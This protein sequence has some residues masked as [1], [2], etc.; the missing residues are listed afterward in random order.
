MEFQPTCPKRDLTLQNGQ[1]IAG[2]TQGELSTE[3]MARGIDTS[4][5]ITQLLD[6]LFDSRAV[7]LS[8]ILPTGVTINS[9]SVPI[10]KTQI[11][12]RGGTPR[13]LKA[14]LLI[15]LLNLR[16]EEI[17][18]P[19]PIADS[20][21]GYDGAQP[22][23][24]ST[25]G[26]LVFESSSLN[27]AGSHFPFAKSDPIVVVHPLHL[28]CLTLRDCKE[29]WLDGVGPSVGSSG[30]IKLSALSLLLTSA[31]NIGVDA[32]DLTLGCTIQLSELNR[33][34]D[35]VGPYLVGTIL[36]L[37]LSQVVETFSNA[38]QL[39]PIASILL[40]R[41][42]FRLRE[43]GPSGSVEIVGVCTL[44]KTNTWS[45][46]PYP[47]QRFNVLN[48]ITGCP[49]LWSMR[50]PATLSPVIAAI[51]NDF[52]GPSG[53]APSGI[54]HLAQDRTSFFLFVKNLFFHGA[55]P[56][57]VFAPS[58]VTYEAYI[59]YRALDASYAAGQH[60]SSCPINTSHFKWRRVLN[61]G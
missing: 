42:S 53:L 4:G 8:T 54:S 55:I 3:L 20:V 2:M 31:C 17:Y 29:L 19:A 23:T 58:P 39:L 22:D 1:V 15:Q 47:L 49:S 61:C 48:C 9:L 40:P 60:F 36:P 14:E 24:V 43:P 30:R 46:D 35:L 59:E 56:R 41:S 37:N 50:N 18:M 26:A 38:T 57:Y 34:S 51:D 12:A 33:I 52:F 45:Q 32:Q 28:I 27:P 5:T 21:V 16:K 25:N 6:K 11:I 13:G 44:V 10:L 7:E